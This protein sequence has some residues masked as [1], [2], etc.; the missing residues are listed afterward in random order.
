[1][2]IHGFDGDFE[3]RELV[4]LCFDLLPVKVLHPFF[5]HRFQ[6]V[7]VGSVVPGDTVCKGTVG[8]TCIFNKTFHTADIVERDVYDKATWDRNVCHDWL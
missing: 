7:Q 8:E 4:H 2:D 3:V 6:P 5:A 1:M